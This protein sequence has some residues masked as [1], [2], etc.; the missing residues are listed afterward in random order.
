MGRAIADELI[1]VPITRRVADLDAIYTL[2]GIGPRLWDLLDG[3]RTVGELISLVVDEYA[4]E[5]S[6]AE[7]DVLQFVDQLESMG[8]IEEA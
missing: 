8:A 3:K 2:D 6:V 7:T 1:L 5:A 4:V